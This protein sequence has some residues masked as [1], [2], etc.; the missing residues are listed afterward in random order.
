MHID[1]HLECID[2]F[3]LGYISH[4]IICLLQLVRQT[5]QIDNCKECG[6]C[7][8]QSLLSSVVH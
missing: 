5:S 4:E 7:E 2:Q 1:V 8:F 3:V 6:F